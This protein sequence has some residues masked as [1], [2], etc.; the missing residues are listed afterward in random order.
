MGQVPL[1]LQRLDRRTTR[2]DIGIFGRAGGILESARFVAIGALFAA[3]VGCS[4]R[5]LGEPPVR[6]TSCS[7]ALYSPARVFYRIT[8]TNTSR[9][10]ALETDI[11]LS[12]RR[13]YSIVK[14][15]PFDMDRREM[16]NALKFFN[17]FVYRR[18][19]SPGASETIELTLNP[20][21][22]WLRPISPRHGTT[23]VAC[24]V[25]GVRFARGIHSWGVF[26]ARSN[27]YGPLPS[28]FAVYKVW[29]AVR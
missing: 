12:P 24:L 4:Q 17:F 6:I 29:K 7:Q 21:L 25:N 19:I 1:P 11:G 13:V 2:N 18:P 16:S 27:S 5:A 14:E 22:R 26:E 9:H 23:N 8:L 15:S 3:S 20:A 28:Y 10:T